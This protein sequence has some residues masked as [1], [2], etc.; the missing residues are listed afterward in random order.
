MAKG[1]TTASARGP[2]SGEQRERPVSN[3]G[4]ES[5]SSQPSGDA[6]TAPLVNAGARAVRGHQRG[7]GVLCRRRLLVIDGERLVDRSAA[8][9]NDTP[10]KQ[11]MRQ[12][13]T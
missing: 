4:T 7:D 12:P 3:N 13:V 10:W 2:S 9:A 6:S 1:F 5:I 8:C 11:A